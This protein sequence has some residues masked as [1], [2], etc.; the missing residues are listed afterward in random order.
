V[1][2]FVAESF[3][4]VAVWHIGLRL[5]VAAYLCFIGCSLCECELAGATFEYIELLACCKAVGAGATLF[6]CAAVAQWTF[7]VIYNVHLFAFSFPGHNS[8]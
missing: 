8:P 3:A 5:V 7:V 6:Y 4:A 2:E 1:V